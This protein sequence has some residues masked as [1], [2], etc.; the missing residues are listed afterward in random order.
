MSL[1]FAEEMAYRFLCEAFGD[2][3]YQVWRALRLNTDEEMA[4]Y[5][6]DGGHSPFSIETFAAAFGR[7][8]LANGAGLP[9]GQVRKLLSGRVPLRYRDLTATQ[10]LY[11][12]GIERLLV[13]QEEQHRQE[14]EG[15]KESHPDMYAV[16]REVFGTRDAPL[17]SLE[18]T[19]RRYEV[20]PDALR[21]RRREEQEA[22]D[23]RTEKRRQQQ[24][25]EKRSH[26][27]PVK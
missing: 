13:D 23:A 17:E 6:K 2:N 15:L 19:A 12:A 3:R 26:L 1:D 20:D 9:F 14:R 18:E 8:R 25:K 16:M 24:I 7:L 11:L 10:R 22:V 5:C 4:T 27:R 21:Q